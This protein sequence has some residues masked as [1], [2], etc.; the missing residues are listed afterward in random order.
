MTL[1]SLKSRRGPWGKIAA[2][3][4]LRNDADCRAHF[5]TK[6]FQI[7]SMKNS[8]Y[9]ARILTEE[10]RGAAGR[11]TTKVGTNCAAGLAARRAARGGRSNA[12]SRVVRPQESYERSCGWCG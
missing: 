10:H 3:L 12:R 5:F 8:D 7:N 1:E 9:N 4:H 2:N 6:D 11:K